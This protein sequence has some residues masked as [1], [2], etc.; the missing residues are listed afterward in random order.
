[1]IEHYHC[2]NDCGDHPQPFLVDGVPEAGEYAGK[3]LCGRCWVVNNTRSIM[4]LCTPET[5]PEDVVRAG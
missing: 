4:V 3:W 1:V 5:C 2:P